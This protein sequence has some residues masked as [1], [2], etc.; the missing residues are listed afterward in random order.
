MLV[1]QKKEAN[2]TDDQANSSSLESNGSSGEDSPYQYPSSAPLLLPSTCVRLPSLNAGVLF[3]P[4]VF[5]PSFLH[6]ALRHA[7]L[8]YLILIGSIYLNPLPC[9]KQITMLV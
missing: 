7:H 2:P 8:P 1:V 4:K 3:A 6:S 9:V 5:N